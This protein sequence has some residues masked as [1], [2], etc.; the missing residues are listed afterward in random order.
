MITIT[1]H[2]CHVQCSA[3]TSLTPSVKE[4]L[5]NQEANSVSFHL[6]SHRAI[7][8]RCLIRA[9]ETNK[10]NSNSARIS[11]V[12]LYLFVFCSFSIKLIH[13]KSLMERGQ[14]W[15]DSES[16]KK[17]RWMRWEERA[18]HHRNTIPPSHSG[19]IESNTVHW[20]QLKLPGERTWPQASHLQPVNTSIIIKDGKGDNGDVKVFLHH[21]F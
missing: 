2:R 17:N 18:V 21:F 13:R 9:E 16:K 15:K 19:S 12:T 3:H 14:D 6:I 10:G 5:V 8:T 1:A 7:K 20:S 11:R 4:R